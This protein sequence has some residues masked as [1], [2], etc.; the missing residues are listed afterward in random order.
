MKKLFLILLGVIL[1][2]DFIFAAGNNI[3]SDVVL[4]Y[5]IHTSKWYPVF[6]NTATFIFA[7]L[8]TIELIW[9]FSIKAIEGSLELSGIFAQLIRL[10]FLWGIWNVF[11]AHPEFFDTLI[12]EMTPS[13]LKHSSFS[14]LA[15]RANAA[16]GVSTVVSVDHLTDSAYVILGTIG[17]NQSIFHPVDFIILGLIGLIAA[18]GVLFLAFRLIATYVKFLITVYGSVLFFAFG[19]MAATRHIAVNAIFAMLRADTEYMLIKLIIGL[20][21]A[22]I[23]SYVPKAMLN[24]GSFVAL[25]IMVLLI[26]ALADM[27][28]GLVEGWFSGMGAQT[29]DH[30]ASVL[31][32]AAAGAI[33]GAVGGAA[34]GLSSVKAAAAAAETKNS[35]ESVKSATG[36]GNNRTAEQSGKGTQ[37]TG[38]FKKTK[39]S[40]TVA[41]S[42]AAGAISGTVKGLTGFST[43]GAGRKSGAAVASM[44]T[45]TPNKDQ[46]KKIS[47]DDDSE[48]LEGS[49]AS[50]K[51]KYVS[52]IPGTGAN[53]DV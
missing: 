50:A 45:G 9:I 31:K 18:G 35:M 17:K 1:L 21:I 39:A 28:H 44:L 5:S 26:G 24:Y 25:L 16:A 53:D 12:G 23:M 49:I 22:N 20:S 29:S 52:G 43:H 30:A 38:S 10:T 48:K 47:G 33:S 36:A 32:G 34:A 3:G 11:F 2:S 8:A 27:V 41:S 51:S 46:E 19:A 37:K 40:A 14:I 4:N 6:K 13:G 42:A 7:S 15:D